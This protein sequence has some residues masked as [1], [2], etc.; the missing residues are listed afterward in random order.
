[1]FRHPLDGDLRLQSLGAFTYRACFVGV[2]A[3][4]DTFTFNQSATTTIRTRMAATY[5][6]FIMLALWKQHR[7]INLHNRIGNIAHDYASSDLRSTKKVSSWS[8]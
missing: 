6:L 2:F 4:A 8:T 5:Q 3:K 1:M 7:R